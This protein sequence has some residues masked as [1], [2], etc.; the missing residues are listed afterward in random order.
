[1]KAK[2]SD[3]I[4]LQNIYKTKARKDLAEVTEIVR[5]IEK[6]TQRACAIEE[7]EIEAFCK[8]AAFI[9]LITSQIIRVPD[10][11][12]QIDWGSQAKL[13]HQELQDE[14]SLLPLH[15]SFLAY[16]RGVEVLKIP[17]SGFLDESQKDALAS[18]LSEYTNVFLN[19]VR[20]LDGNFDVEPCKEKFQ[21]IIAEL[22]GRARGAELHNI[23]ALTGGMVAQEVIKVITKQYIPIDNTCVFD[24]ILSKTAVFKI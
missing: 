4:Q 14:G 11:P 7:K 2:S 3:Y 19:Q 10:E 17:P 6:A 23:S 5:T 18:Y 24:G 1:M 13:I 8:G 9:K 22:C 20:N 16:D 12:G 21:S 15:I